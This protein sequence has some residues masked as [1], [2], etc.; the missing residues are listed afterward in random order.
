[1]NAVCEEEG[2][3]LTW[4]AKGA[5]VDVRHAMKAIIDRRAGDKSEM[6]LQVLGDAIR[7]LKS[8]TLTNVGIRKLDGTSSTWNP[9][10]AMRAL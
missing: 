8:T 2:L 10:T 9:V 4:D 5:Y 3:K 6:H 7:A 1:M